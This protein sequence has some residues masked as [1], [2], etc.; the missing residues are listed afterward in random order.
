VCRTIIACALSL[1][2]TAMLRAQDTLPVAVSAGPSSALQPGEYVWL[3]DG[4]PD[5]PVTLVVSLPLQMAY[6]YRANVLIGMTSVSTGRDGYQTPVGVFPILQKQVKH[7]STLYNAA[8]MNYMQRLTWDGVA[9]H[10]GS[11]PGYPTSHGCVHLPDAF[12]EKLYGATKFD[13]SV[14]ITNEAPASADEALALISSPAEVANANVP[15]A[16]PTVI[17]SAAADAGGMP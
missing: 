9:L 15:Q 4:A 10:A 14:I 13:A 3:P 12:A 2:P 5:G 8:P 7:R 17:A 16:Q 11:T 1:T 6:A